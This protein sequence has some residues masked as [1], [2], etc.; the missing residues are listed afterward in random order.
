VYHIVTNDCSVCVA[1]I[2][3]L[4]AIWHPNNPDQPGKTL[5]FSQK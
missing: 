5:L 1:S 2:M 3:R 4:V